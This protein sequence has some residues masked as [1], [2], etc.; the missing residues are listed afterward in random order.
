MEA[1]LGLRNGSGARWLEPLGSPTWSGSKGEAANAE[2][3]N[4]CASCRGG[5]ATWGIMITGLYQY[6]Q[7]KKV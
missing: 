4:G 2:L 5:C 6:L 1:F 3:P 7:C